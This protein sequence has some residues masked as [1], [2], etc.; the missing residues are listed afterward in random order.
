MCF[1]GKVWS[2]FTQTRPGSFLGAPDREV[3]VEKVCGG[4]K[5]REGEKE[6]KED[7]RGWDM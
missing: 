2:I 7:V 6:G 5:V 4:R 1:P 3:A